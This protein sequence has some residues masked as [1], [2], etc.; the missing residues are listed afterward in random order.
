MASHS[1]EK[2]VN[3]WGKGPV[4]I[5]SPAEGAGDEPGE[6]ALLSEDKKGR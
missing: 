2:E 4:D 3:E 5:E 6:A 1:P